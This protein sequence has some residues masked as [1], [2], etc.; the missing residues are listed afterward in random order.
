MARLAVSPMT[1]E[2]TFQASTE[3]VPKYEVMGLVKASLE[4]AV[5]NGAAE[6]GPRGV[7][8]HA[9]SPGPVATRAS[10]ALR[11]FD[12]L[13]EGAKAHPPPGELVEIDD[14]GVAAAFLA[15]TWTS[16]SRRRP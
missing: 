14:V 12:R 10:S 15:G 2:M 4:F 6:L 7:R 3:V 5:W 9:I 11:E 1:L 8:V 13:I 16:S